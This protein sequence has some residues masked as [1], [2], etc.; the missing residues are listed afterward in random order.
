MKM[1]G[2]M[3]NLLIVCKKVL[4]LGVVFPLTVL[5]AVTVTKSYTGPTVEIDNSGNFGVQLPALTFAS[6]DF[7]S[8]A[9]IEKVTASIDWTKNRRYMCCTVDWQCLP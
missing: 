6:G 8:G 4:V 7:P 9:T 1:K 2:E 3:M 5:Q